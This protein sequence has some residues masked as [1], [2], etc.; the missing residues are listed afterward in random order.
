MS[1]INFDMENKSVMSLQSFSMTAGGALPQVL[2]ETQHLDVWRAGVVVC[3][4]STY[5]VNIVKASV[6][7]RSVGQLDVL[8]IIFQVAT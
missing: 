7:K 4:I 1:A 6:Q 5:A 8:E 2:K 3:R